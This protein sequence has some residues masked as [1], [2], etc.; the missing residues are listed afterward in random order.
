MG[1]RMKRKQN[2][3]MIEVDKGVEGRKEGTVR[4]ELKHKDRTR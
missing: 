1:N 4:G 2:G 3:N